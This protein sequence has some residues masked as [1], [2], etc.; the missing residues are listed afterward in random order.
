MAT[1]RATAPLALSQPR[2][3]RAMPL[4]LLSKRCRENADHVKDS[5]FTSLLFASFE[6]QY[7][8]SN[9]DGITQ[10]PLNLRSFCDVERLQVSLLLD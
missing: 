9:Q 4:P 2:T 5:P 3:E 1:R 10:R 8:V 6:N 7:S